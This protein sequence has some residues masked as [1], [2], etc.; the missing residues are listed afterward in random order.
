MMSSAAASAFFCAAAAAAFAAFSSAVSVS[1]EDGEAGAGGAGAGGTGAGCTGAGCTGAAGAA[2]AAVGELGEGSTARGGT[3]GGAGGG[4]GGGGFGRTRGGGGCL[5]VGNSGFG[6]RGGRAS[7]APSSLCLRSRKVSSRERRKKTRSF[8]PRSVMML[9][10]AAR[11]PHFSDGTL[12]HVAF[13]KAKK[14]SGR[15]FNASS[16]VV[17]TGTWLSEDAFDI[18]AQCSANGCHVGISSSASSTSSA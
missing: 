5:V 18:D 6:R 13:W 16:G 7:S 2:G 1:E 15:Y 4:G 10:I 17:Y 12:G 9:A 3:N 14:R 11:A 8:C